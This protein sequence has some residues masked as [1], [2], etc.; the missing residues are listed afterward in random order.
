MNS[1]IMMT[2]NIVKSYV[3]IHSYEFMFSCSCLLSHWMAGHKILRHLHCNELSGCH[4]QPKVY[5]QCGSQK[6]SIISPAIELRSGTTYLEFL[7]KF[8]SP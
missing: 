1:D 4:W 8:V 6:K 2:K 5:V 7:S 3:R